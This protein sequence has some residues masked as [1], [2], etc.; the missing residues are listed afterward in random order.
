MIRMHSFLLS[1]NIYLEW[2]QFITLFDPC[3]A[4]TYDVVT[5]DLPLG[6][7]ILCGIYFFAS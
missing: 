7:G 2:D 6:L 5:T 1:A 4:S 3:N